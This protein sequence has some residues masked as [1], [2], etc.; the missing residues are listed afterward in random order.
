MRFCRFVGG[1][2]LSN[3]KDERNSLN[4]QEKKMKEIDWDN[5]DWQEYLCD[6]G[7]GGKTAPTIRNKEKDTKK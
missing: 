7:H 6:C 1:F 4:D 5:L 3:K 2:L